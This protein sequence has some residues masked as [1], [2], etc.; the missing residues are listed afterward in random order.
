MSLVAVY[1]RVGKSVIYVCKKTEKVGLCF[2]AFSRK[3][4]GLVIY[5]RLKHSKRSSIC[6]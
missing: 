5:R 6:Q 1:E 3:R 4:S 2:M